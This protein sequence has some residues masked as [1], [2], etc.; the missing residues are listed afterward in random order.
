[1]NIDIKLTKALSGKTIKEVIYDSE[2]ADRYIIVF[3]DDTSYSITG[4]CDLNVHINN[5]V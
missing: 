3:T 1:M 2:Y 4:D 5:I